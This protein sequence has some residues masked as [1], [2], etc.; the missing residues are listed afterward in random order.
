MSKEEIERLRWSL[1]TFGYTEA[2]KDEDGLSPD[3]VYS[4]SRE[5]LRELNVAKAG[6]N[7]NLSD[8]QQRNEFVNAYSLRVQLC[9]EFLSLA[10]PPT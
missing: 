4:A 3:L 7:P 8:P 9:Q 2:S 10:N 5:F 1:I 6:G